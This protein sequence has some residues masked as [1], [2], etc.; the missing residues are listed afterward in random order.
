MVRELK[1]TAV[2]FVVVDSGN[3]ENCATLIREV[4]DL[5][6]RDQ[7]QWSR[8]AN[9]LRQLADEAEAGLASGQA[10]V[11]A[12]AVRGSQSMLAELGLSSPAIEAIIKDGIRYGALAGKVSGAGG[13]G[14][15]LLVAQIGEGA[16]LAQ[17][18][19]EAGCSVVGVDLV[20]GAE[21]GHI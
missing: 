1:N 4:M 17:L 10:L 3:R 18:L 6:E 21:H 12:G 19:R 16:R 13:G 8:M 20:G 14:A 7:A 15:V 2:D 9:V 5:R 11:V